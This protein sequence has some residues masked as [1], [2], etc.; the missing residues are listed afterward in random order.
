MKEKYSYETVKDDISVE[1]V[2]LYISYA[3]LIISLI[4]RAFCETIVFV[5]ML[6]ISFLFFICWLVLLNLKGFVSTDDNAVTFGRIFKKRIEYSSIKS[7]DLKKEIRTYRS[8]V[9]YRAKSHKKHASLVELIIFHCEDGDHSF[10]CTLVPY[11]EY[12]QG[13]ENLSLYS[14][15]WSQSTFARLKD[16]IESKGYNQTDKE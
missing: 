5:V 2:P 12:Q 9:G 14:K 4:I 7:I 3:L 6:A 1:Y 16:F 10:A 8:S 13:G 15:D 11:H